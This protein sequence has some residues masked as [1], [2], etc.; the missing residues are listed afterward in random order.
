M[1]KKIK[2]NIFDYL[3]NKYGRD[4]IKKLEETTRYTTAFRD[5]CSREK[6]KKK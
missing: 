1:I 4:R 2:K 3:Y 5:E 6:N